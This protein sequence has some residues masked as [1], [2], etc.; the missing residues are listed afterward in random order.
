[1]GTEVRDGGVVLPFEQDADFY[2]RM[3]QKYED[4]GDLPRALQYIKRAYKKSPTSVET[5][6][7]L[8]VL[9]NHMQRFEDSTRVLMC[10]G[11]Y[12]QLPSEALFGLAGNFMSLNEFDAARRCIEQYLT[13]EGDGPFSEEAL[14]YLDLLDDPDELADQLGLDEGE[15][16]ELVNSL[17]N[18]HNL[19]ACHKDKEAH[20][21]LMGLK[22]SYKDSQL[23][24][25]ELALTE[26]CLADYATAEQRLFEL[27]KRDSRSVRARCLM[28]LLYLST[29]RKKDAKDMMDGIELTNDTQPEIR[30]NVALLY[31][32]L[33]EFE[34]ADA[35]LAELLR[36]L[37]YDT[38]LLH[39]YAYCRYRLG[40]KE[41]AQ[42]CYHTLLTMDEDDLVAT[43]YLEQSRLDEDEFTSKRWCAA[44][45]LPFGAALPFINRLADAM[46][47]TEETEL[48]TQ[49][50]DVEFRR[51]VRWAL[52]T[53]PENLKKMAIAILGIVRGTEAASLLQDFLLRTD[54]ADE[55]KQLAVAA[56]RYM[57][58]HEPY[59]MYF[60]GCW[61]FGAIREMVDPEELPLSYHSILDK[62][63]RIEELEGMPP[64]AGEV[65][66]RIF[67]Y[68]LSMLE[69]E[70]PRITQPQEQAM[71]A[72]FSLMAA[73]ALQSELTPE[74]LCKLFGVTLR[75]L[76]NALS[77]IF[78]AIEKE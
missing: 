57:G 77:K 8:A 47:L 74:D 26:L 53:Q 36:I 29:K 7:S 52:L 3:G 61:Q 15:D 39:Q 78:S 34:R 60:N 17:R 48:K 55:D 25:L 23:L 54:E 35:I 9:Y 65:A 43:Y 32:E 18:A 63:D 64:R 11:N 20:E 49:W 2:L 45:E 27:M 76:N 10:M 67:L 12:T 21:Y 40:D 31:L 33:D 70:Y 62:L 6:L 28:A 22:E 66:A 4:T 5:A 68:Y 72:A 58:V 19:H 13:A 30:G 71:A 1:M 44:Y 56:L 59:P 51:I 73:H 50:E 16:V 41:T 69:G 75:R 37:P 24:A 46:K 42:D 14:D 38:Q